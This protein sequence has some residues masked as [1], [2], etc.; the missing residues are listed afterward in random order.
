[1]NKAAEDGQ[2]EF[3]NAIHNA[4]PYAFASVSAVATAFATASVSVSGSACICASVPTL[5]HFYNRIFM[6]KTHFMGF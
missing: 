4:I 6:I 2:K 3:T 5:V 1:M